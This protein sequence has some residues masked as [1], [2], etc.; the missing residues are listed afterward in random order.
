MI[1]DKASHLTLD[2]LEVYSD[3]ACSGNP[4]PGGYG[5]VIRWLSQDK[6]GNFKDQ[7]YEGSQGF[8]RTTNNRMEMLGAL[9]GLNTLGTLVWDWKASKV[10]RVG[11]FTTIKVISDSSYM[12]SGFTKGWVRVWKKKNWITSS[13]QPVKNIDLWIQI[14]NTIEELQKRLNL[15]TRFI[16]IPGHKGWYFNER[17][18]ELAQAA[19]RQPKDKLAVDEIYEK[20]TVY[21]R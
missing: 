1:K 6:D 21:G 20:Q 15:T 12:C 18:D 19:A 10:E 17:C 2:T 3:G 8:R 5:Y 7:T 9:E 4:G 11:V 14:D 16:H 13:N